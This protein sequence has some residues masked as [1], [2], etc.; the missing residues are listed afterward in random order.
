M[1]LERSTYGGAI[2][3]GDSYVEAAK[4]QMGAIERL[5]K[6]L[7]GISGYYEKEMRRDVDKRLREQIAL[8][9]EQCKG[10]VLD[11]QKRLLKGS[12]LLYMDDV[13]QAIVKLQTLID[14]VRHASYGYA[15][16]FD[17]VRIKEAQLDALHRFDTAMAA[18]VVGLKTSIDA[19]GNAIGDNASVGAAIDRLVKVVADLNRLFDR[20]KDAIV[21]PDLLD[22]TAY[23]PSPTPP[24]GAPDDTAS[25]G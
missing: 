11:I 17:T 5:L 3:M 4:S 1:R 8:A 23:A 12:G 15:G 24:P 7:P 20:R 21:S 2:I 19:L 25:V 18:E 6:G 14:R 22:D 13:D 10:D 16:L 9:L